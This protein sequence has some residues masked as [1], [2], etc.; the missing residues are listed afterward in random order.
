MWSK[1][2]LW[3]CCILQTVHISIIIIIIIIINIIN[4][5]IWQGGYVHA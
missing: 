5:G 3:N 4:V 2:R 1:E